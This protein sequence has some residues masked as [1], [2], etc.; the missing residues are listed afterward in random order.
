LNLSGSDQQHLPLFPAEL[1]FF[2]AGLETGLL[3][4]P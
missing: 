3:E 1:K 4:P 2:A